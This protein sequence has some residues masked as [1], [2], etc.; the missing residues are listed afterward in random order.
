MR[1]CDVVTRAITMHALPGHGVC[2]AQS[3]LHMYLQASP[4]H[5]HPLVLEGTSLHP[6]IDVT[7]KQHVLTPQLLLLPYIVLHAVCLLWF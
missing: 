7:E 1:C 3:A 6:G 4:L 2:H 5:P